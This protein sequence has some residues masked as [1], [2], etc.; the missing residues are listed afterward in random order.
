MEAAVAAPWSLG[1]LVLVAAVFL[2]AGAVKGLVGFGLPTVSL[3]LLTA[4]LGLEAAL[5]LLLVP[6]LVT[7]LWQAVDGGAVGALARRLWRFLL[8]ATLAIPLGGLLLAAL[9][10]A[11]VTAVLG[12]L[13]IVYAGLGLAKLALQINAR[14]DLWAGPVAGLAN[15]VLTGMTGSF[16]VPGLLYLQALGLP[17]D[18]LVQAMGLLFTLSTLGLA[19][20]LGG[21]G[22][23]DAELGLLSALAVL[24]AL[25]GMR[26]GAAWRRRI[27]ETAFRRVFF[28]ALLPLG[29][30]LIVKGL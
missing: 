27:S 25:I 23:L 11:L 12:L 5:A 24:P 9:S 15:G 17:R 19:V 22:L 14:R 7:N 10:P 20:S 6:S 28:L 21:L 16:V 13:L 18:R 30:A 4:S 29:A 26:L 2:L 8:P 3:A 1:G